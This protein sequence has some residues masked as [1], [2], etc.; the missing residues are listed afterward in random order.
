MDG[1]LSTSDVKETIP[2]VDGLGNSIL[3][4]LGAIQ[5]QELL[6]TKAIGE[7][8]AKVLTSLNDVSKKTQVLDD[9]T[10]SLLGISRDLETTILFATA[11]TLNSD[12]NTSFT[13]IKCS[14]VSQF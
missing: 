7:M 12:E 6:P 4:L 8:C 3:S 13:G 1:V 14:C 10:R 9:V 2:W 5:N 11:G